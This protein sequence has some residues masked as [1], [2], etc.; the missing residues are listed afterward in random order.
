MNKVV[1]KYILSNI[2][3]TK[4][5]TTG[6][7]TFIGSTGVSFEVISTGIGYKVETT[8]LKGKHELLGFL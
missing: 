1:K 6:Y 5:E 2:S 7:D 8:D 4:L 3:L